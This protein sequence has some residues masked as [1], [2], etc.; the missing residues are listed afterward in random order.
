MS[1][2]LKPGQEDFFWDWHLASPDLTLAQMLRIIREQEEAKEAA[3]AAEE[4]EDT[5]LWILQQRAFAEWAGEE[6]AAAKA[7]EDAAAE[8]AAICLETAE[9]WMDSV[10]A[11][12]AE[13]EAAASAAAEAEAAPPRISDAAFSRDMRNH[14]NWNQWSFFWDWHKTE[15][16]LTLAHMFRIIQTQRDEK[17]AAESSEQQADILEWIQS[18]EAAEEFDREEGPELIVPVVIRERP[19]RFPLELPTCSVLD[20]AEKEEMERE[21]YREAKEWERNE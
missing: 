20:E 3:E 17:E 9:A 6:E 4:E 16:T 5:Q 8:N 14:T 11:M 13:E 7:E 19:C 1:V 15:P 21:L 12:E 18:Q 2:H 10:R